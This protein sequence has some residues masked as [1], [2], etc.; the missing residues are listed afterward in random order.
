MDK[1]FLF[2]FYQ[3]TFLNFYS[4]AAKKR[5]TSQTGLKYFF[6][7]TN[8]INKNKPNGIDFFTYKFKRRGIDHVVDNN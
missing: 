8:D 3:L 1:F 6:V 2:E 4:P 5:A 7:M